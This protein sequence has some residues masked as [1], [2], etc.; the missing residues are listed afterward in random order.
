MGFTNHHHAPDWIIFIISNYIISCLITFIKLANVSAIFHS[1]FPIVCVDQTEVA[2]V[3]LQNDAD[4]NAQTSGGLTPLHLAA[5]YTR[6]NSLLEVLLMDKR[7]NPNIVN[8][9]N[10]TAFDLARRSGKESFFE[11]VEGSVNVQW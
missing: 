10:E 6:D 8:G 11:L 5:T 2:S 3:L 4:I 7:L 9:Q 1:C